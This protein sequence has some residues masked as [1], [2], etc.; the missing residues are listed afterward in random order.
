MTTKQL[1]GLSR[2]GTCSYQCWISNRVSPPISHILGTFSHT[3]SSTSH[4]HA[5]LCFFVTSCSTSNVEAAYETL[6]LQVVSPDLGHVHQTIQFEPYPWVGSSLW[7]V[8][9]YLSSA[10]LISDRYP[11]LM[12]NGMLL[13]VLQYDVGK[14]PMIK[15]ASV[16]E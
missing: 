16:P 13:L 5:L 11:V 12:R 3:R 2:V 4:R 7:G 15:P 1:C 14:E 10:R 8:L 9:I 6:P